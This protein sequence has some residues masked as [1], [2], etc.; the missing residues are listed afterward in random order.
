MATSEDYIK[1]V[2]EQ[3]PNIYDVRYR[4][5]FGEY[6]IYVNDKP[7]FLVCDSTVYIK[8]LD[9]IKELMD[10]MQVGIP[11]KGSKPHYILSIDDSELCSQ[12]IAILERITPLPKPRKKKQ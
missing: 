2:S 10:T 6:M 9:D 3:I 8:M 11:Y 1:Y 5:M 7:I 12:V 4:K